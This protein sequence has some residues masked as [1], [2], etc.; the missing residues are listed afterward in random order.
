MQSSFCGYLNLQSEVGIKAQLELSRN[1][2]FQLFR[3]LPEKHL[4]LLWYH[5]RLKDLSTIIFQDVMSQ[6]QA[7]QNQMS[8]WIANS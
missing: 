3:E 6:L 7:M 8:S 4:C 1:L 2:K 5:R